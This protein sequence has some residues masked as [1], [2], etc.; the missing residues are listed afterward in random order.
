MNYYELLIVVAVVQLCLGALGTKIKSD[1]TKY[2]LIVQL[3]LMT[4][5]VGLRPIEVGFDTHTYVGGFQN[6]ETWFDIGYSIFNVFANK[7]FFGNW[8]VFLLSIALIQQI[9]IFNIL[10]ESRIKRKYI[11]LAYSFVTLS[12]YTLL[13]SVNILRQGIAYLLIVYTILLFNKADTRKKRLTCVLLFLIASSFHY[14]SSLIIVVYMFLHY[15]AKSK[16]KSKTAIT[17]ILLLAVLNMTSIPMTLLKLIP[18][19]QIQWKV[20]NQFDS[21]LSSYFKLCFYLLHFIILVTWVY[22]EKRIRND[23]LILML[24]QIGLA[25]AILTLPTHSSRYIIVLDSLLPILYMQ[26]IDE[27]KHRRSKNMIFGYF[28]LYISIGILSGAI[29][30]NFSPG[31][32]F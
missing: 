13:M 29:T 11:P 4:M 26:N 1:Q 23:L 9:L 14:P 32:L 16:V 31:I 25:A 10:K 20:N 5:F 6:S 17:I 8:N 3:I 2:V 21:N 24:S 19:E 22:R 18:I 15:F 27:L 30:A 28:I 7:V 12:T